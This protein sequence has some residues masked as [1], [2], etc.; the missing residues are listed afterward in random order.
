MIDHHQKVL[1]EREINYDSMSAL[2]QQLPNISDA[3]SFDDIQSIKISFDNR[4][5]S[6]TTDIEKMTHAKS[7][8]HN[9]L[10]HELVTEIIVPNTSASNEFSRS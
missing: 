2:L 10:S 7:H 3:A 4:I 6:M 8:T 5:E 1:L 9:F